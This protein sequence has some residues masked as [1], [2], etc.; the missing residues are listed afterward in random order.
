MIHPDDT[1]KKLK[2]QLAKVESELNKCRTTVFEDGWQTMRH[3]R[4]E[5]KWDMLAL[6]KMQ[7]IQRIE[8]LEDE[9]DMETIDPETKVFNLRDEE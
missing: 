1:P 8:D 2:K 9:H 4:K 7:L 5:R 3:A 6:E